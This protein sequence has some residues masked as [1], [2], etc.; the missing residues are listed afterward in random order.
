MI[1]NNIVLTYKK[2]ENVPSYVFENLKKLNPDKEVLFFS[3]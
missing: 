2:K 3:D 1:P